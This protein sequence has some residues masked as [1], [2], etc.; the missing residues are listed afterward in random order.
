[1]AS[2]CLRPWT[3]RPSSAATTA[4]YNGDDGSA[5]VAP[6]T[7]KTAAAV[8]SANAA[9]AAESADAAAA[10]RQHR[11]GPREP[12]GARVRPPQRD[13]PC[14]RGRHPG[15]SNGRVVYAGE[16]AH[17]SGCS[18][19]C[20]G[21]FAHCSG[22]HDFCARDDNTTTCAHFSCNDDDCSTCS[23]DIWRG[24]L[25][26][27]VLQQRNSASARRRAAARGRRAERGCRSHTDRQRRRLQPRRHGTQHDNDRGLG[28][29]GGV[30]PST[31]RKSRGAIQRRTRPDSATTILPNTIRHTLWATWWRP[32]SQTDPHGA[33]SPSPR[34]ARS[35]SQ[36]HRLA[37]SRRCRCERT[38]ACQRASSW[39]T[40][41]TPGRA[42]WRVGGRQLGIQRVCTASVHSASTGASRRP[43]HAQGRDSGLP[44][45]V[46][47]GGDEPAPRTGRRR[48]QLPPLSAP[49][50]APPRAPDRRRRHRRRQQRR[51]QRAPAPTAPARHATRARTQRS[52]PSAPL[53]LAA[54]SVPLAGPRRRRRQQTVAQQQRRRRRHPCA[55]RGRR[56]R[57]TRAR[58]RRQ[59]R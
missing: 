34:H 36:R 32:F 24:V 59:Q 27:A 49:P 31:G 5:R 57:R 18:E 25:P 9:A 45:T 56:R 37:R 28:G 53:R 46:R 20:T 50:A 22:C 48:P 17:C 40:A 41:H 14:G 7:A 42:P 4:I 1:M 39:W 55:R 16:F 13:G 35:T 44:A 8:A 43:A 29:G 54:L 12:A 3:P 19:L 15:G 30:A 21:E 6:A 33:A 2:T 23:S 11:H 51:K 52:P 58:R 47:H 26:S 38:L 10:A